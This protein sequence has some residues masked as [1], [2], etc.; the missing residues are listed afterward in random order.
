MLTGILSSDLDEFWHKVRPL[1]QRAI[2]ESDGDY[3]IDDIYEALWLR[4][5][6]LWVWYQDGEIIG[7]LV[8]EILDRPENRVCTLVLGG[9]AGLDFWKNDTTIYRWAKGNGCS[10]VE[11][12]GRK[13]WGRVL[14]GWKETST[15]FRRDL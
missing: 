5:M 2:D 4:D 11:I 14:S 13:G 10:S 6:Q 7:A 12:H 15:N 3:L 1:I 9:G 8:T